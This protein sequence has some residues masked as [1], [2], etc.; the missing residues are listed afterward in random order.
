MAIRL[1]KT[2]PWG[3]YKYNEFEIDGPNPY[4][5]GGQVYTAAQLGLARICGFSLSSAVTTATQATFGATFGYLRAARQQIG[6]EDL[7]VVLCT[8]IAGGT[9]SGAVDRSALQFRLSVWG[10]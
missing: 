8:T 10:Y 5:A 1:V 3:N 2:M 7:R 9:E 4:T 6:S